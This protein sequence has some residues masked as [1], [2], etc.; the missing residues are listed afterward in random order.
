[1]DILTD[2]MGMN[3]TYEKW[4]KETTLPIYL[5]V[6]YCFQ[7]AVIDGISCIMIYP[8]NVLPTLPAL[9]KQIF[10]IQAVE[11]LP[12]VIR[13]ANMS[14]FRRKSM[15]ENKIPFIVEGKQVYLPFMGTLLQTKAD[16]SPLKIERFMTSAQLL[17]LMYIYQKEEKLFLSEAAKKLSYSAM[18]ITRAAKQLEES[19]LFQAKKDGVKKYLVC[20]CNKRK[21]YEQAK[22]YLFS[23]V[24][25]KGY[26]S[27]DWQSECQILA[28]LS[29][30]AEKS[31]LN[32][33]VLSSYAVLQGKINP[34]LLSDELIDPN[35]QVQ[36]EI[37][38]YPP[39]LFAQSQIA[40][41][42][43]IAL[44]LA[45]ETDERVES[46]IEEMLENLWEDC[47]GSRI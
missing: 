7:K 27:K 28:G 5:S 4:G 25:K 45:G 38:K 16:R 32:P 26:V 15:I 31:M 37:W 40:D 34:T 12:V 36:I 18:T 3:V 47:D 6:G 11:P 21:L 35:K 42:I 43:S 1:M 17:F 22:E 23:P 8:Q 46:T 14:E 2:I 44:S 30:L 41:P 39:E 19:G 29:A 9:K 24:I 33:D 10:R 13:V 20:P